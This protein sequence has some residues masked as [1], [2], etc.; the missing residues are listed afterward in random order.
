MQVNRVEF[1]ASEALSLETEYH[2]VIKNPVQGTQKGIILIKV[3][4]PH[5]GH[6]VAGKDDVVSAFLVV[7]AVNQIKEQPGVLLVK[8]TVSNFINNQAGLPDKVRNQRIFLSGASGVRRHGKIRNYDSIAT[9][10]NP[11]ES[12]V[13]TISCR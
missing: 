13:G 4:S 10:Y 11:R 2:S 7:P 1:T 9:G 5:G 12:G 3:L 6:L 8:L